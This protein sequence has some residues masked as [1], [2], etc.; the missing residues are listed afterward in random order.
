[1]VSSQ[2]Q[3]QLFS[4]IATCQILQ[5]KNIVWSALSPRLKNLKIEVW[6]RCVY[7][8]LPRCILNN[9]NGISRLISFWEYIDYFAT[10][11]NAKSVFIEATQQ[12]PRGWL[13]ESFQD[14]T[15]THTVMV[16]PDRV[17]CDCM[18]YR[19]LG[20]RIQKECPYFYKLM[21]K[22]DFFYGQVVCHHSYKV[23]QELGYY[24]FY[25]Y[26]NKKT[27]VDW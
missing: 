10:R 3:S 24:D 12:S 9:T 5:N 15:P 13:V 26:I 21:K 27:Y 11:S 23:I 25:S 1:M 6:E 16:Y 22:S 8:Y 7:V 20:N 2:L 14:K 4:R 17:K 18:L 19:C